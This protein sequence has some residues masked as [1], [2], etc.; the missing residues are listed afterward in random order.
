VYCEYY[1]ANQNY[2]TP[3]HATMLRTVRHKL[4]VAHGLGTGELYDL[5]EDPSETHNCWDDSDYR[6]VKTNMM[7]RLCDRMAWTVDPLPLRETP[8]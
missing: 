4:V 2:E 6:A 8:W 7:Q 1:N 3:A 5:Q